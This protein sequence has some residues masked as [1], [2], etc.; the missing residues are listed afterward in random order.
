MHL[1]TTDP[2]PDF[3]VTLLSW[4][5]EHRR[6]LPWR[7]TTDPYRIW[8]S[9]IILQQT[10][11]EQ[12]RDYYLRFISRW[13]SVQALA[14]AS[15]DEV[16]R[17]WQGL[18]YYSRARN[19]LHAARQVAECDGFPNTFDALCRLKGVGRYTAAAIGSMAFGLDVAAVDGN[20]FRVLSRVYGI[21]TPINTTEGKHLFEQLA[22]SLLPAGRAAD[23]NQAMMDFGALQCT[24]K[25]PRCATCPLA[26]RCVALN[27]QRTA[28]L[29]VKVKRTR[30]HT[31]YL[32]YIYVRCKGH[33]ALRRRGPSD[34]WQGLWEPLLIELPSL[35]PQ[36]LQAA[37]EPFDPQHL[38]LLQTDVRHQLTHRLLVARFYLLDTPHRPTLPP[39]YVWVA[40]AQLPSYAVPR[41]VERLFE[42]VHKI[43][44]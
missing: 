30:V 10:R 26:D 40:E 7:G 6:E 22:Q 5:A 38:Q 41:L 12:G 24:P 13:P 31:R 2:T 27:Q 17:E 29:P 43:T 9:E 23:F 8:V 32:I 18:G 19:M 21:D 42:A 15:E 25:Q 3:A 35:E 16:L 34:I 37:L 44:K 36:Q 11:I 33:T 28:L 1:M 20:V 39:D 4:Y 14:A